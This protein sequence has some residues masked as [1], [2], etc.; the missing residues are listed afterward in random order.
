MRRYINKAIATLGLKN[1]FFAGS[2]SYWE[3]RYLRG[4]N[5]GSGSYNRLS[6]FK[7]EILNNFCTT[8]SIE[9]VVEFGSGDGNQL[10][11]SNYHHY[12]GLDVSPTAVEKCMAKFEKYPTRSFYLLGTVD[13]K[14]EKFKCELSLSLDVIF[15]L[16]EDSVFEEYIYNL[17]SVST[18]Y[19]II[20]SS[21]YNRREAAHVRHR[22][23]TYFV[24]Q[25]IH[26]FVLEQTIKNRYPF[27]ASNSDLTS[28]ADFYIYKKTN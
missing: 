5:S 19:V 6:E 11:L 23:F 16:V 15:H 2:K 24:E 21:N 7:A 9:H 3:K 26:N 8:H 4:G 10:S 14:D 20:Y 18:D 22:C 17:F 12:V 28:F 27:E 25:N 1:L 13:L